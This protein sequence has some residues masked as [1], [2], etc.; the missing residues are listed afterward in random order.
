MQNNNKVVLHFLNG[1]ITKGSTEDF[2]P[3][4]NKFHLKDKDTGR[5]SEIDIIQLK[6]IFFVKN[7]DGN[8]RYKENDNTERIGLG[9]KIM[10]RFKDGETIKGYTSGYSP[11]R[12]GFFTF[13][14]DPESNMERVFVLKNATADIRFI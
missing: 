3:N 14:S 9:K 7:F 5:I 13:P 12:S 2:F 4:K 11:E 6:G 8:K 1:G 10:I